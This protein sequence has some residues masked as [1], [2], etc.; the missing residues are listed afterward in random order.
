MP[1]V[2]STGEFSGAVVIPQCVGGS[3]GPTDSEMP[4]AISAMNHNASAF[5]VPGSRTSSSVS[6]PWGAI[7]IPASLEKVVHQSGPR[8]DRAGN[9]GAARFEPAVPRGGDRTEHPLVDPEPA[10]PLRDDHID[11]FRRFDLQ[12]VALYHLDDLRNPVRGG[13]LPRTGL[14]RSSR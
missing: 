2:R 3:P 13:Q 14:R 5:A 9:H 12:D 11:T 10:E 4:G 6:A 1:G 8:R 7:A